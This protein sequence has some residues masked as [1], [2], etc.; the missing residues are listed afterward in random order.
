MKITTVLALLTALVLLG[1]AGEDPNIVNPPPGSALIAVRMIN[2]VPDAQERKLLLDL[3]YQT[4][5]VAPGT[6]GDTVRAPSDSSFLEIIGAASEYRSPTRFRFAQQSVY[7]VITLG[8]TNGGASGFDSIAVFNANAS[9]TTLPVAQ[10]RV[11]N[12]MPDTNI[13]YDVRIGCPNGDQLS[14]TP[15]AFRQ[16][17][18]YR[19]V[20]P[21]HNVFTLIQ[22]SA[23]QSTILGTYECDLSERT[24]YSI[25]VYPIQGASEPQFL[26]FSEADFSRNAK[27]AFIPVLA[28]DAS[29][30]VCNV[31]SSTVTVEHTTAGQPLSVSQAPGTVNAYASVA[32]CESERSDVFTATYAD[33]RVA[34]DSTSLVVRGRYTIVTADTGADG[35]VVVVPPCPTVYGAAGKAIIRVVHA[36]PKAGAFAMS[37]GARSESTAP[38]GIQAGT[39]LTQKLTFDSVALPVPVAPGEL[40]LT[41]TTSN[42]P[43]S[44]KRVGRTNVLADHY[45]LFVVANKPDGSLTTYVLDED[46]ETGTL[47]STEDAVLLRFVNGSSLTSAVNTTVSTVVE[48]A[49]VHY[50]NSF[51]TSVLQGPTSITVDGFT[52]QVDA[53]LN[54]RTLMVYAIKDPNTQH[55]IEIKS[56]PLRQIPGQSDRRVINATADVE[57]VSVSYDTNFRQGNSSE[58]VADN[59]PFGQTSPTYLLERDR[60]GTMYFFDSQTRK[61]IYTLPIDFGPLG[62]SYSLIVVGNKQN[63]YA[64]IVSQEY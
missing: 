58:L 28:R 44:I 40:P 22:L 57:F 35:R 21:G 59:V 63:G 8:A 29:V 61:D 49:T 43:T 55:L 48:N 9:L 13:T 10:I 31:S 11:I 16:S 52:K 5:F 12:A 54:K 3:G 62:N 23:T 56:D 30:R 53:T 33:S 24:P 15:T 17:S 19:E 26:L 47:Q 41:I 18:L 50:R 7:D 32:T 64:V 27:R 37:V 1:C 60:R 34:I 6:I 36:A 2:A 4:G 51:V 45:Y 14:S 38:N 46:D 42:P 25:L 20:P 39:A